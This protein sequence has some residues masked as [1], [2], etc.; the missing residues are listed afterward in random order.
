MNE[1]T[2]HTSQRAPTVTRHCTKPLIS[3]KKRHQRPTNNT[4]PSF[5]TIYRYATYLTILYFSKSTKDTAMDIT[6]RIECPLPSVTQRRH[7]SPPKLQT[8]ESFTCHKNEKKYQICCRHMRSFKLKMYQNRIRP[9][10]CP[11][12]RWEAYDALRSSI[13]LLSTHEVA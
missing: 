2:L 11:G 8:S 9:E 10:L 6:F 4:L 7:A 12:S 5:F 3:R 13:Y 1:C